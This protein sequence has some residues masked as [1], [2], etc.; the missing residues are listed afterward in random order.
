MVG[1]T[2]WRR[3]TTPSGRAARTAKRTTSQIR[4]MGCFLMSISTCSYDFS[5]KRFFM[6]IA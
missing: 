3:T 6:F 1:L 5:W 2:V 4:K